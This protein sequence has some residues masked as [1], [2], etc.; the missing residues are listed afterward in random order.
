[1]LNWP[2]HNHK[3]HKLFNKTLNYCSLLSWVTIQWLEWQALEEA[4][5]LEEPV[6]DNNNHHQAP[7]K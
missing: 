6:A 4:P 1:M 5:C 7:Y 2:R 3:L